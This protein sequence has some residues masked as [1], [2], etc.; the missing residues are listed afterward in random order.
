MLQVLL[1]VVACAVVFQFVPESSN[2]DAGGRV[3]PYYDKLNSWVCMGKLLIVQ[4]LKNGLVSTAQ[5]L[6]CLDP[7]LCIHDVHVRGRLPVC[8]IVFLALLF[9]IVLNS[10]IRNMDLAA[11]MWHCQR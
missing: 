4:C 9:F 2:G 5:A 6:W 1:E 7:L 10:L 8:V 3:P 11:G